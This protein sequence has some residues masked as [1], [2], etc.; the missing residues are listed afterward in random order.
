MLRDLVAPRRRLLQQARELRRLRRELEHL[1]AQNESMRTGMRR[2][3]S[4][5]YRIDFKRR[6]GGVADTD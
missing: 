3:V 2:C 6:Q 5:E 4:C 1:K